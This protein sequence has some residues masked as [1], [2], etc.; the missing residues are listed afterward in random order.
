M[1]VNDMNS[2][3]YIVSI[4][5]LATATRGAH[6]IGSYFSF[7]AVKERAVLHFSSLY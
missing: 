3:I 4:D 1:E 5:F 6:K 7:F 2:T